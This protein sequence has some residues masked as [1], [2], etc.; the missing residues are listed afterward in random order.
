MILVVLVVSTRVAF[1]VTNALYWMRY[2]VTQVVSDVRSLE[3]CVL[4]PGDA[5]TP[6]EKP[7]NHTSF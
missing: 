3:Q 2:T 5:D 4:L 7:A 6:D 1:T